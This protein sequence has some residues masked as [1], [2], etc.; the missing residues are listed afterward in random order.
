M[1]EHLGMAPLEAMAAGTVP[2]CYEAGGPKEI[3]S[4]GENGFLFINSDKLLSKTE[5]V[6]KDEN[7]Y[8]KVQRKGQEYIKKIFFIRGV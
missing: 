2:F 3:I 4:D 6:L 1:V 7:E 5:K 8:K